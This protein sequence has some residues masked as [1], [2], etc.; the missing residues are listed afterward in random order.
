M[1]VKYRQF[2]DQIAD[3]IHDL[4]RLRDNVI[5]EAADAAAWVHP[6]VANHNRDDWAP[7]DQELVDALETAIAAL[8]ESFEFTEAAAVTK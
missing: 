4:Q 6:T 8:E 2:D 1:K 7:A 5:Q 3:I